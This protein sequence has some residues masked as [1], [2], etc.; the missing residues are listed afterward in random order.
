[1]AGGERTSGYGFAIRMR[2]TGTAQR[3]SLFRKA[4]RR[5]LVRSS[6]VILNGFAVVLVILVV[7]ILF[8][9]SLLLV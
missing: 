8:V 7:L 9:G 3:E 2:T 6:I 1:M 5:P 4:F